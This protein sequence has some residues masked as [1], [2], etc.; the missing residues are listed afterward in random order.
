MNLYVPK[1]VKSLKKFDFILFYFKQ[2]NTTTNRTKNNMSL[3]YEL[4]GRNGHVVLKGDLGSI[5]GKGAQG[6][7]KT[8]SESWAMYERVQ[9]S[10]NRID[11]KKPKVRIFLK[12]HDDGVNAEITSES[13]TMQKLAQ[14]ALDKHIASCIKK[15]QFSPQDFIIEFPGRL[16]GMII[17]KKASGLNRILNDTIYQDKKIMIHLDDVK[18][19]KT[20]RLR[21][22]ELGVGMDEEGCSKNIIDHVEE[23]PNR[24]FL[25]WPPSVEDKYE[26]YITITLSFKF[27]E[28][29]FTDQQLYIERL[30]GVI[31]ERVQQIM[32]QDEDRMDE[33]N[34]CLG[35]DED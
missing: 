8:I 28:K 20:A 27:D 33:I 22:S 32:D 23:R 10:E 15:K 11:E 21:V 7:K 17:G 34:E 19:A 9:A 26:Q 24:S 13:E 30:S 14:R 4:N 2:N 1:D 29:P 18:T 3:S 25:G 12:D 6:L 31:T 5:I 16:L 35:F